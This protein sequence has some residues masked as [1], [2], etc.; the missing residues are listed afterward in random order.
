[1][2]P[3]VIRGNFFLL[4]SKDTQNKVFKLIRVIFEKQD[5]E[6]RYKWK[7]TFEILISLKKK[8]F[9]QDM[10]ATAWWKKFV[11]RYNQ[12]NARRNVQ[13]D[14]SKIWKISLWTRNKSEKLTFGVPT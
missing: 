8:H 12:Q 2:H 13:V 4:L 3:R 1:M 9:F 10:R 14:Q 6:V 5:F 7:K 11:F